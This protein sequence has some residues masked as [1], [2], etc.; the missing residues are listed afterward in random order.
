MV[1]RISSDAHIPPEWMA[2]A[3]AIPCNGGA[4]Q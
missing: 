3:I 2:Q 1:S 4:A